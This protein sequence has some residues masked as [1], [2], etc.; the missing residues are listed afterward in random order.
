MQVDD[1]ED[2]EDGEAWADILAR[3]SPEGRAVVDELHRA[4]QAVITIQNRI[5][6][7]IEANRDYAE[8]YE[9]FEA[10]FAEVDRMR[11]EVYRLARQ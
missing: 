5:M 2:E 10:A 11:R 7:A 3:R 9:A 4:E 1:H 6:A 8:D